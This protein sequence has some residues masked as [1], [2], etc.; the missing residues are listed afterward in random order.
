[1]LTSVQA[2][3]WLGPVRGRQCDTGELGFTVLTPFPAAAAPGIVS[4]V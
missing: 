3:G 4:R 2:E 1:M